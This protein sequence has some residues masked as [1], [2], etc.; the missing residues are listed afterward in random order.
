MMLSIAVGQLGDGEGAE[1]PR[2]PAA[3]DGHGAETDR[4][5]M[6]DRVGF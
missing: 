3:A 5:A 4:G 2:T 1:G 6:H